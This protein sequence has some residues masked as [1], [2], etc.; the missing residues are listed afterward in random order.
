MLDRD[1]GV[2]ASICFRGA[3]DEEA[4]AVNVVFVVGV[5]CLVRES[6]QDLRQVGVDLARK[7]DVVPWNQGKVHSCYRI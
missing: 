2:Q 5:K 7:L 1:A 6:P 4:P 3:Q